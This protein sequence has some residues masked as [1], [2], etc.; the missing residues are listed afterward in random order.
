[1]EFKKPRGGSRPGAG[2]P[3]SHEYTGNLKAI[4]IKV[5]EDQ[6]QEIYEAGRGLTEF[7]IEAAKSELLRL[8]AL[9]S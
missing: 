3:R 7:Y 5:P 4:T 8:K 1:M 2:R 6:I 9:S